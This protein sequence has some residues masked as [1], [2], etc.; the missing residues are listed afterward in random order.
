MGHKADMDTVEKRK[1]LTQT[2]TWT[3]GR[4]LSLLLL[5]LQYEK[6]IT[7][8]S[9]KLCGCGTVGNLSYGVWVAIFN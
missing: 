8:Q 1:L 6:R 5:V 7:G 3:L 4:P 2:R 9:T